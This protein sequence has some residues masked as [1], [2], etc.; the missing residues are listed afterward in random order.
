LAKNQEIIDRAEVALKSDTLTQSWFVAEL[1]QVRE[2]QTAERSIN[3]LQVEGLYKQLAQTREQYIAEIAELRAANTKE[4]TD[5]RLNHSK[6]IAAY[7][8]KLLEKELEHTRELS[9]SKIQILEMSHKLEDMERLMPR[10][11]TDEGAMI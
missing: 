8:Q 1:N 11:S 9:E 3:A 7:Q 6:E 5:L 10:R 2:A 4:L